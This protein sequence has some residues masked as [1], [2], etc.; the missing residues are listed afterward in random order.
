MDCYRKALRRRKGLRYIREEDLVKRGVNASRFAVARATG[1]KTITQSR[2]AHLRPRPNASTFIR[3]ELAQLFVGSR[4]DEP[5]AGND[6]PNQGADHE[7]PQGWEEP[8]GEYGDERENPDHGQ[9]DVE[10]EVVDAD[11]EVFHRA[12][13]LRDVK[14]YPSGGAGMISHCHNLDGEHGRR[15][16]SRCSCKNRA[17]TRAADVLRTPR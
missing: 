12:Y 15:H 2:A 16:R 9:G 11:D 4:L 5:E 6:A 1:M 7:N 8:A 14:N 17:S 10:D 13:S 3:V